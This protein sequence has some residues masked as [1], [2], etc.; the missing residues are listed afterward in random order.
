MSAPTARGIATLKGAAASK[1]AKDCLHMPL[2]SGKTEQFVVAVTAR[3]GIEAALITDLLS[4][5]KEH[6]SDNRETREG[7]LRALL[8]V[9]RLLTMTPAMLQQVNR[10]A[11]A[12]AELADEFGLLSSTAVA[13]RANSRSLAS[14][15]AA[16]ANRWRSEGKVFTVDLDGAQRFPG[17]QFGATGKPLR[18][19]AQ[20][21]AA[22]GD[23][24][25]GWELA[26][27][28]TGSN[29]WLGGMRPVDVLD[30][31]PELVV[32]AAGRL[33]AEILV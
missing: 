7:V 8:P 3:D 13:E 21:L 30:S 4:V 25:S 14:N 19:I 10:N 32:E 2:A 9:E 5:M 29:G 15:P 33:A 28:F 11:R 31:D 22:V 6:L 20:V 26:L 24:L 12:H 18:V 23:R 16:L 27:W 17:F 1:V